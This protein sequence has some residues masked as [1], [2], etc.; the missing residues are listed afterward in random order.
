MKRIISLFLTLVMVG[1]LAACGDTATQASE[2]SVTNTSETTATSES[3]QPTEEPKKDPVTVTLFHSNGNLTSGT[4]GGWLG[5]YFAEQGII[6]DIWPYSADK[7]NAILASGDYPD[8]MFFN[9]TQCDLSSI[10]ES[11]YLLDLYDYMD[12]LPAIRDSKAMQNAIAYA[13]EY[14]LTGTDKLGAIPCRVGQGGI[15]VNTGGDG[16]MLNWEL[17]EKIGSPEIT[18]L[19]DT[20][21]VFKKMQTEWPQ[22]ENG[23]KTYAMHLYS[24]VDAGSG[25]FVGIDNVLKI[26][27]YTNTQMKYFLAGNTATNEFEYILEDDGIYKYGLKYINT[28]YKEG[29]LD[30]DSLTYDRQAVINIVDTEGSTLAGWS[31]VPAYETKGFMPVYYDD[32]RVIDTGGFSAYGGTSYVGVSA[33]SENIEA[34]LKVVELL[35]NP[36]S[37][38]II[39]NGP[40]GELWEYG[41]DGVPVLTEKGY[42]WFVKG[43]EATI[44][45]ETFKNFNVMAIQMAG[46]NASFGK[47]YWAAYWPEVVSAKATSDTMDRWK[48]FYGLSG[49]DDFVDLLGDACVQIAF[50]DNLFRFA[51]IPTD[52][53]EILW[54]AARDIIIQASW[55]MVYAETDAEFEKLWTDAVAECEELGIEKL[56]EARLKALDAAAEIEASLTK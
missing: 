54:T 53:E 18:S 35:S 44:N 17:Y 19:E 46:T 37:T 24:D 3:T 7:F 41:A 47:S 10:T 50:D 6:L 23:L 56:V 15:P 1:S 26:T 55:K 4:L 49:E 9:Y 43:E 38:H 21:D 36:D 34:A 12:Y 20:V 30:P 48:T 52:E 11:G 22:A 42:N 28:L 45:G 2:S 16:I 13:Q 8:V 14:V 27:G 33:K 51:E 29:L 40:E 39:K 25:F 32:M 31:C 5:E